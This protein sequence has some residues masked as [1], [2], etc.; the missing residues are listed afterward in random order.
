MAVIKNFL[1]S[2]L[3]VLAL[4][5]PCSADTVYLKNGSKL[6][7]E[8]VKE[9]ASQIVIKVAFGKL[10]LEKKQIRKIIRSNGADSVIAQGNR[11]LALGAV[12]H[13]L[14]FY[15]AELTKTPGQSRL[16]QAAAQAYLKAGR[17][18]L[19]HGQLTKSRSCF[20]QARRYNPALDNSQ[21]MANI[22]EREKWA[23]HK[24]QQADYLRS[25]GKSSQ[26]LSGYYEVFQKLPEWHEKFAEK[27]A[28]TAAAV[29]HLHLQRKDLTRACGYYKLAMEHWPEIYPY[30][31]AP[32][33]YA[34]TQRIINDYCNKGK[35]QDAREQ[36]AGVLKIAPTATSPLFV[37][38][39]CFEKQQKYRDAWVYYN[40][41]LG[42]DKIWSGNW[43][44]LETL[45]KLAQERSGVGMRTTTPTQISDDR[46]FQG[47][48]SQYRTDHFVVMHQNEQLA[49]KLG[50]TLEYHWQRILHR[51]APAA[52]SGEW[53][54]GSRVYLY[55]SREMYIA[56]TGTP[57]WSE[58][59]T[60]YQYV[61]RKVINVTI[62]LYQSAPL[63]LSSIVPHELTHAM[64]LGFMDY[65]G[66]PPL[67]LNEGIA[68]SSEPAF[69]QRYRIRNFR[70]TLRQGRAFPLQKLMKLQ[71]YP[72][73]ESETNIFYGQSLAVVNFL[74]NKY[75]SSALFELAQALAKATPE[76][77]LGQVY[78][79]SDIAKFEK[80]WLASIKQLEYLPK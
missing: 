38:G 5:Q 24:L 64:Y 72:K 42:T 55:P 6:T 16:R 34:S 51:L 8:I 18:Y 12:E 37:I 62:H 67:W 50:E 4:W 32:W 47:Q 54:K 78:Q 63:L 31:E 3:V 76:Q 49:V 2:L 14:Q 73:S 27:M 40:R 56:K 41:V 13:A 30:I 79:Y 20:N 68:M 17:H 25:R 28:K 19:K 69:R 80:E 1:I 61:G 29:G 44:Q 48:W 22:A 45:R 39:L 52:W 43:E 33:I 58:G 77:A 75:G 71:R 9:S 59:C 65:R 15:E 10:T 35:W 53:R 46:P 36:L 74:L 21:D 66:F 23:N 70:N 7:G 11:L 57:P 26:A 60:R